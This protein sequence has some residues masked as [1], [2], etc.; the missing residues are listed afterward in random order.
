MSDIRDFSGKNR[1][2]TGT[3]GIKL[4]SGTEAQ[5]V[6]ETAQIR[7]NTDTNL[8]E[9]YDG[10]E[11][12]PID[13]PPTISSISP[14]SFTSD[15]STRFTITASG[16]NFQSGATAKFVGNDGTEYSSINLNIIS[17]SSFT[18]QTMTT[19]GVDN[20]PYDLIYTNP[21]G[22]AATLEDGLDAGSSPTFSTAADTNLFTARVGNSIGSVTTG[23]ATD[24][25][26]QTVT[27]TISAGSLPTGVSLA[28][29]G[30]L[31]GTIDSG[32]TAQQYTFTIQASDG[33]NT[34][35]RQFKGTAQ[36]ALPSGGT[37][38][39]YGSA[40]N[41]YR[42]HTFTSS[43]TWTVGETLTGVD[44]LVVA[45]GGGGGGTGGSSGAGGGGG[46]GGMIEQTGQT[47]SAQSYT[48]TVGGAGSGSGG[49]AV[50]GT[51]G[52]QSV[53]TGLS[54]TSIGGGG[55]G[56]STD[57]DTATNG[58]TGGSGGGAGGDDI[59]GYIAGSAGTAGQ[60]NAGGRGTGN[61]L[62]DY[63]GGGGGKGTVGGQATDSVGAGVGGAGQ[64]NTYRTGSNITYAGGGGGGGTGGTGGSGGG[65]AGADSGGTAGQTNTGGGGGGGRSSIANGQN[66]GSGI[67]VIRYLNPDQ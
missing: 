58:K 65:G 42:V 49:S 57:V 54:I 43:G 8:A 19:M 15:G 5:R 32:A 63:G 33:L 67:V 37:I 31:S 61:T 38:S 13:S 18:V 35:T 34:N 28:S 3:T 40:P 23:Q 14:T 27:H 66:G 62:G 2:F 21:S 29:N 22:L 52:G 7:F 39:T 36:V 59:G 6:N 9:Y 53:I 50:E 30:T 4:P 20:E 1:K 26:G 16:S 47:V 41:E 60:G 44:W 46:A 45:G 56:S 12:K 51:N 64:G 48:V 17:S 11:W 10:T 24:A 55:G 25:E